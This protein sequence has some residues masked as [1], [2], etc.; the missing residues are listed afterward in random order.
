[1]Y[2]QSA[3]IGGLSGGNYWSSSEAAKGTAWDQEFGVVFSLKTV[4]LSL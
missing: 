1:M 3:V 2:Q 4:S